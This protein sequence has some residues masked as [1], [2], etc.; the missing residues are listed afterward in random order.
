VIIFTQRP[1][2]T[3]A[4]RSFTKAKMYK[5][6]LPGLVKPAFHRACLFVVMALLMAGCSTLQKQVRSGWA[7]KEVSHDLYPAVRCTK[8]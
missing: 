2:E 6:K 3:T 5:K 8:K 1:V 4:S 7:T